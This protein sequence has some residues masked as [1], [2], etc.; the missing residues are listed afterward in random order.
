[1]RTPARCPDFI[2]VQGRTNE[3]RRA[4]AILNVGRHPTFVG[5]GLYGSCARNGGAIFFTVDGQ[6]AAVALISA[7]S[8]CLLVLCVAPAFRNRGLGAAVVAYC[9]VSFARVI[10]SA[11]PFFERCGFISVG[12]PKMGKRWKTQ[13]MCL[14]SLTELAGRLSRLLAD[15]SPSST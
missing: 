4:K 8:N 12:E 7:R 2:A 5:R 14:K 10:E 1:M 15:P 9:Q 11:V 6:D 3:Y 13:I